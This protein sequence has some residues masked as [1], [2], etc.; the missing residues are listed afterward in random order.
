MPTIVKFDEL[1]RKR[2]DADGNG[3]QNID[4]KMASVVDNLRTGAIDLLDDVERD[5]LA[6]KMT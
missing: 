3:L 6:M 5:V 1:S 2:P 4:G